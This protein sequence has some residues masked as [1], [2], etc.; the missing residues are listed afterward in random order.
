LAKP[1]ITISI[2]EQL[3]AGGMGEV[4][5]AEDTRLGRKIALKMLPAFL[6]TEDEGVRRFRQEARTA[7]ALNHPNIITIYE[8]GEVNSRHFMAME[9]IEGETLFGSL[10]AGLMSISD[11]LDVAVQVTSALCAAHI[12][13]PSLSPDN[14]TLYFTFVSAEAA[15]WLM[16]IN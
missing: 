15:I 1:S 10:K 2:L 7:S 12:G 13:S 14:K 6:T 8:I 5:L 4:Y 11:A 9:F 3:G 16:S